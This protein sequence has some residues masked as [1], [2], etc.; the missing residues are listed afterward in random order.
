LN[1][2][3]SAT[4][5]DGSCEYATGCTDAKA[6]NF[7]SSALTD[8]GSCV[9]IGCGD[10]NAINYNPKALHN[11]A[12]CEYCPCDTQDYFYVIS[13]NPGCTDVCIKVKRNSEAAE[14]FKPAVTWC[15]LIEEAGPARI[16]IGLDNVDMD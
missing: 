14:S 15:D 13:D 8:D 1:Y 7:S 3:A 10:R 16:Q 2:N 9:Y 6:S 12:R 4:T 5:D 11:Q